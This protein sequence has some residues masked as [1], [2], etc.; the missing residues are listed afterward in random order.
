M[1]ASDS[2]SEDLQAKNFLGGWGVGV[3]PQTHPKWCAVA[4]YSIAPSNFLYIAFFPHPPHDIL[5]AICVQTQ[6]RTMGRYHFRCAVCGNRDE[7]V[8]EMLR[9][10]IEI[11][12]R[13]K[14]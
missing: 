3:C 8:E 13:L 9:M 12:Q 11:P 10:G 14:S 7:F 6:A 1:I 5:T 2:I 4:N